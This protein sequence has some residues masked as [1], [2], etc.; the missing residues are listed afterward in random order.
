MVE[1]GNVKIEKASTLENVE[2]ALMKPVSTKKFK[3][4]GSSMVLG[5]LRR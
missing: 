1:D 3:W 4:C 2:D 5:A